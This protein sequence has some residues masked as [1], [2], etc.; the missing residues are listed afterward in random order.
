M[1]QLVGG[2][3]VVEMVFITSLRTEITCF[4]GPTTYLLAP[5]ICFCFR[6]DCTVCNIREP[7]N[8]ACYRMTKEKLIR[9]MELAMRMT[10][11]SMKHLH[12]GNVAAMQMALL[13]KEMDLGPIKI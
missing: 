3:T 6:E 2:T 10:I 9:A 13:S 7:R 4:W 12:S 5:H 11:R 8:V 1:T